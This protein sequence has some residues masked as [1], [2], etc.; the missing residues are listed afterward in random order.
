MQQPAMPALPTLPAPMLPAY[1]QQPQPQNMTTPTAAQPIMNA[2]NPQQVIATAARM[3]QQ[4][5]Q[6]AQ[7]QA[8]Q[9]ANQQPPAQQQGN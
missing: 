8:N 1:Q 5:Q 7:Q 6:Q 2:V 9:Q 4:Q 3:I